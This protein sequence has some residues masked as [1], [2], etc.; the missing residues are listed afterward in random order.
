MNP[1]GHKKEARQIALP[2]QLVSLGRSK[3]EPLTVGYY[4]N[5]LSHMLIDTVKNTVADIGVLL[6]GVGRF[7]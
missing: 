3:E 4:K 6:V 5:I 7:P 1:H 2:G